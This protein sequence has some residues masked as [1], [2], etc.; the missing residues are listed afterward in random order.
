MNRI[1]SN[2]TLFLKIFLPIFWAVFFGCFVLTVWFVPSVSWGVLSETGAKIA[3]SLLYL[4]F[5]LFLYYTLFRLKRV[6]LDDLFVY[7]YSYF[8]SV[9]Y[10]YHMIESIKETQ[11]GPWR[12]GHM[13]LK[14]DGSFGRDIYF[15]ESKER[16]E[17]QR[18]ERNQF[19]KLFS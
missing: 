4:F 14:M 17:R 15:L 12:L 7:V 13:R 1:S 11:I 8:K 2:A 16:V 18:S 3:L 5:L 9:R 19:D 10:P 6:E